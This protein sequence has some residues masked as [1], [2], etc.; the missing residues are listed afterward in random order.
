M[1]LNQAP[2]NQS[3]QSVDKASRALTPDEAAVV[4]Q[5]MDIQ[6]M[7]DNLETEGVPA[8]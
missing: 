8:K 1:S 5:S 7:Y 2:Q 3:Q 6:S 4:K